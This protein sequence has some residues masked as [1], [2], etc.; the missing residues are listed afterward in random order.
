LAWAFDLKAGRIERTKPASE[1]GLREGRLALPLVLIG[2]VAAAPG[3][4]WYFFVRGPAKQTAAAAAPSI[5]VLPFVNMS[6]DA[7]NEYFST[8]SHVP[9]LDLDGF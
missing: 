6:A 4:V 1:Y 5:A 7:A 9:I 2:V 3:V 8:G